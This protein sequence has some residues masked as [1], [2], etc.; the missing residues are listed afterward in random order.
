MSENYLFGRNKFQRRE[1]AKTC[2]WCEA[3]ALKQEIDGETHE[4]VGAC[5]KHLDNL[6]PLNR[7]RQGILN[8]MS[9]ARTAEFKEIDRID[10]DGHRVYTRAYKQGIKT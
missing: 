3:P 8:T 2:H 10:R 6:K 7:V 1:S 4:Y 5:K 9:A